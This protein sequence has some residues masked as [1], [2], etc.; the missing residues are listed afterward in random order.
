MPYYTLT[1]PYY[2]IPY[3]IPY[4]TIPYHTI[5]YHTM[6]GEQD[7]NSTFD[8]T[9]FGAYLA[10][11]AKGDSGRIPVGKAP[12][13]DK[14]PLFSCSGKRLPSQIKQPAPPFPAS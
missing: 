9:E 12:I 3:T 6:Q 11:C 2:T 4:Y 5:P 7:E 14:P 1:I 13:S 8:E 10:N